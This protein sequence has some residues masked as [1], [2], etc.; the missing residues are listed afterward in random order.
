MKHRIGV[1]IL[2]G[3]LGMVGG[4]LTGCDLF[5]DVPD[6]IEPGVI[7]LTDTGSVVAFDEDGKTAIWDATLASGAAGDLLV[8]GGSVFVINSQS[9]VLALDASNG[10]ELWSASVGGTT[11]GRLETLGDAVFVQTA[12]EVIGLDADSGAELWSQSFDGL[13]GA[14][15][16]GDGALFVA[17]DPVRRLD[18]SSG[19]EEASY[20]IGDSYV[21][22]IVV[23]GGMVIVGGRNEVVSLTTSLDEE[24]AYPLDDTYTSGIAVDSGDFYV[25]TDAEG[26]LGFDTTDSEPFMEVLA[27]EALDVPTVTNGKIYVTISYGDLI[28]I[29]ASDGTED[30][31]WSTTNEHMGG[32]RA[33]GSS[34]YLADGEAL[35]GLE[36]DS[37]VA[38]WEQS[39][40]G[41]ILSIDLI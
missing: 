3:F 29:D 8:D 38:G 21:P 7:V 18:P 34:V 30:W 15:T 33:S 25:A 11:R 41:M 35:V 27:G 39:L 23:S 24:W 26:L 2:V 9:S 6:D 10:A 36:A 17:G 20:D 14:L 32:V 19:D 22:D 12:D 37:G 1:G 5:D 16:T 28:R 40:G 13:S 4:W 31:A